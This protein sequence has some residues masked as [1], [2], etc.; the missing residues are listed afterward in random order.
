[1]NSLRSPT[2]MGSRTRMSAIIR[3]GEA[4]IGFSLYWN[5][6]V[7]RNS[8]R[9]YRHADICVLV[10]VSGRRAIHRSVHDHNIAGRSGKTQPPEA[11]PDPSVPQQSEPHRAGS[12][13][14]IFVTNDGHLLTNAHVVKD[15][16]EIRVGTGSGNLEVGSL[17]AKDPDQRFGASK[18]KRQAA[19]SWCASLWCQGRRK[20]R[21]LRLPTQPSSRYE[22]EFHNRQRDRPCRTRR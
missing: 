3:S 9:T 11:L 5:H 22:R 20:R 19:K 16:L 10:V 8:Y 7:D 13:T 17:V 21:G 2:P 6:A 15:C 4:A 14:G 12:G 18:S 1:M